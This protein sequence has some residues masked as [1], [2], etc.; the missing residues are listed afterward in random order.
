MPELPERLTEL[1]ELLEQGA[2]LTP[3][4]L[5]RTLRLQAL[6]IAIFGRRYAEE[7]IARWEEE[8]RRLAE[9]VGVPQ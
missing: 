4:D 9:T 7:A 5:E 8:D 6:D 3:A 2:E 1:V